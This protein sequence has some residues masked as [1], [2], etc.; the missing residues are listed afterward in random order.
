MRGPCAEEL[1]WWE[2]PWGPGEQSAQNQHQEASGPDTGF[3]A[4]LHTPGRPRWAPPVTHFSAYS[5]GLEVGRV[6]AHY[7]KWLIWKGWGTAWMENVTSFPVCRW[8]LEISRGPRLTAVSHV[9]LLVSQCKRG[10]KDCFP[11]ICI[12][13]TYFQGYHDFL[14]LFYSHDCL[15]W[16]TRT[17]GQISHLFWD[18]RTS[19]CDIYKTD[20]V[21][22][23]WDIYLFLSPS[24][25][26]LISND[27]AFS[28]H[29][30][31]RSM[32]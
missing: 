28:S 32:F 13:K 6:L 7:A 24:I 5:P 14:I 20:N 25:V 23:L 11:D 4:S 10:E 16:G 31:S 17:F 22:I 30:F 26:P 27:T 12:F 1:Q 3:P 15:F 2:G 21:F 8:H 9:L 19:R 29:C 18:S